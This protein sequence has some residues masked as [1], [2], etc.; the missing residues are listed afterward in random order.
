MKIIAINGST[1][2]NGNTSILLNEVLN[3]PRKSD[4]ET[5]VIHLNNSIQGC[6]GCGKCFLDE[7]HCCIQDDGIN[8]IFQELLKA[9]GILLGSPVYFADVSAKMK[10]FIERIGMLSMA[11]NSILKHKVGAAVVA[12]R[13]GGGLQAIDTLHHFFHINEM[14]IVG[15]SYWNMVYG[16]EIGTVLNDEEG[17]SNMHSLGE[18]MD[19]LLKRVENSKE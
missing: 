2:P 15:A 7:K 6:T 4:I 12:V 8:E 11:N 5:E 19:W 16:K 1:H 17:L 10:A 9:D 13:R 3:I 18:N 14:F